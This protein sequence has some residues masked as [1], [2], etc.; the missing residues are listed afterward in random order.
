M[1]VEYYSPAGSEARGCCL[2]KETKDASMDKVVPLKDS[3]WLRVPSGGGRHAA[4]STQMQVIVFTPI[5]F[6]KTDKKEINKQ[7]PSMVPGLKK[8]QILHF[9][10]GVTL[11]LYSGNRV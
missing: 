2:H 10:A 3:K 8:A 4:A 11:R 9:S 7:N 6:A 1:S 5:I